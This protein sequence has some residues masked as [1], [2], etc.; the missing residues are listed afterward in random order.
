MISNKSMLSIIVGSAFAAILGTAPIASAD[1]NP[2]TTQSLDKSFMLAEAHQHGE[3]QGGDSKRGQGQYGEGKGSG[4]MMGG[5][6]GMMKHE[7][8]YAHMIA[9]HADALKLSDAQLGKIVRLHFKHAQEHQQFKQK[10]RKSMMEFHQE[11]M[12]PSTDDAALRKLGKDHAEAFNAMIEQHIKDRNAVNAILSADQR[13]QLKTLKMDHGMHG[14]GH[15]AQ[16][17]DHGQH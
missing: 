4:G 13:S 16:G 7:H 9:S 6:G 12:K 2:V 1:Y 3:G 11:S 15:G 14:G 10:I 5:M 8:S 17:G